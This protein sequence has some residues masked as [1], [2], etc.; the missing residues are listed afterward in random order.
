M[1]TVVLGAEG[2]L[3]REICRQIGSSAIG[4][5]RR[6]C[7]ITSADQVRDM[8]ASHRPTAVINAAAYTSVDRAERETSACMAVN[9]HAV[10]HLAEA[11]RNVHCTLV[12]ISTDYVFGQDTHR[13]TPYR[14][15]DPPGPLGVYGQSKLL[16]ERAAAQWA[17]H[18][19]VR[20]C[21]LYGPRGKPNQS[22]FVDTMLRLSRERELL[23]IVDDQRC[24][25]SYVVDVA[26]A[27]VFLLGTTAYGTYHVT[28]TGATTWHDLAA[29]IFRTAGIP[30]R[31]ERISTAEYGAPAPRPAYS[32]L[33]TS[34][35]HALGGPK[36]RPWQEALAEYLHTI[37]RPDQ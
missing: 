29:E 26:R 35:Y 11:C 22:N 23:R 9:A 6:D 24:T 2:Q 37:G 8:L 15:S 19:I 31:L 27:I 7:D 5:S 3:G 36:M 18:L 12:Q 16:G 34:K 10:E 1:K 28:N 13:S 20:T 30:V 32:V 25:P 21:G 4:L 33:D 17:K 14:E